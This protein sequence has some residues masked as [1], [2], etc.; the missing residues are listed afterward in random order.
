[1]DRMSNKEDGQDTSEEKLMEMWD[2]LDESQK[3]EILVKMEKMCGYGME[4]SEDNKTG[5][6]DM[7]QPSG[8]YHKGGFDITI[9]AKK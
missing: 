4:G 7:D 5:G 8:G 2:Q 3:S 9:Q 1:M 6:D